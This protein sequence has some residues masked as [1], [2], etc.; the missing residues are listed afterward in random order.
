MR[1]NRGCRNAPFFMQYSVSG[2][3]AIEG[4]I[5]LSVEGKGTVNIN[6][7]N[8]YSAGTIISGGTL[9]PDTLANKEGAAYGSL[10]EASNNITLKKQII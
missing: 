6:N 4:D 3:G 8:K 10:G 5:A 1:W 7:I 2:D 9:A